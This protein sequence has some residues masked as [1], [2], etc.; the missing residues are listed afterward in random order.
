M[1]AADTPR[2]AIAR[3]TLMPGAATA[4]RH[5]RTVRSNEQAAPD[6]G[7]AAIRDTVR[8]RLLAHDP[9]LSAARQR[10]IAR[11]LLS[12]YR[13]G[14]AYG[15]PVAAAVID[16]HG[17]DM[18]FPVPLSDTDA[19]E[20]GGLAIDDGIEERA[21]RPEA[22]DLILHPTGALHRVLPVTAGERLGSPAGCATSLRAKSCTTSMP[23]PAIRRPQ[24]RP[25]RV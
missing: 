13:P 3:R 18:S 20:G 25:A 9:F 16:G 21:S 17:T 2:P 6:P 22:G 5:A 1:D 14:M 12:R 7:C 24:P 23:P 4:G 19:Y 10:R 8:D 11:M 15:T